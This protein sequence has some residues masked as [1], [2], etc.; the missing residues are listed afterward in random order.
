MFKGEQ[1]SHH[2]AGNHDFHENCVLCSFLLFFALRNDFWKSP[3]T[4]DSSELANYDYFT[5]L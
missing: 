5:S 2:E 4:S 1:G 3:E